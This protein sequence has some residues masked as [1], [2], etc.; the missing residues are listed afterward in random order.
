MF[1][2]QFMIKH[3]GPVLVYIKTLYNS[4]NA[5]KRQLPYMTVFN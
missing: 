2:Q 3:V 1:L 4:A 5:I